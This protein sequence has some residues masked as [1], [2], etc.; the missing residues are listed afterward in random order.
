MR[1]YGSSSLGYTERTGHPWVDL[2]VSAI[3]RRLRAHYGVVEFSHADDCIFR[4]EITN[5]KDDFRF[6]DG[7]V[8]R[9]GD[10]MI[11]LHLWNERL[12]PFPA[13][14]P[15]VAWA[16]SLSRVLDVSLRELANYLS[17]RHELNDI[18]AI[19]ANMALRSSAQG[20]QLARISGRYGFEEVA[21]AHRTSLG[22]RLHRFGEN[23]LI[24]LF[25]MARN[26]GALRPDILRRD[27]TLVFMS[28]RCLMDR[29]AWPRFA[30]P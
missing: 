3:D 6:A 12:P 28:R 17:T 27:R 25:V 8:V 19:G 1:P 29:Y 5:T 2:L 20:G 15:S 30:A 7:T 26:P 14:T 18:A 13:G 21:I 24:S 4:I 9:A 22:G 23:V 10:R 16:R 11:T